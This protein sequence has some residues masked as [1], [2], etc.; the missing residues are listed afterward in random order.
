M[1]YNSVTII[2]MGV[3][4]RHNVMI[5]VFVVIRGDNMQLVEYVFVRVYEE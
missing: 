2:D 1:W 5:C 3:C 4:M